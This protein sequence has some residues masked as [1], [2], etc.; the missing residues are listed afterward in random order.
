M[1]TSDNDVPVQK[2][3]DHELPVPTIWR[4]AL[5]KIVEAFAKRD[6]QLN[7]G[8]P[9]VA[10]VSTDTATQIREYIEEYGEELIKLPDETWQSSV[11]AWMGSHW[12]V[13][14]DLWTEGEGRSDLVLHAQVTENNEGGYTIS[15]HLVYVP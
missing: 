2:S 14:V 11:C 15:V 3:D 13:L 9:G 7:N 4:P 12:E 10:N 8:I 5:S 6:Y 1:S